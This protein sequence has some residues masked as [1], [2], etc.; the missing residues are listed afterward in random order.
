MLVM[1]PVWHDSGPIDRALKLIGVKRGL[2]GDRFSALGLGKFR[3]ND[4][5]TEA[6]APGR[7]DHG[8]E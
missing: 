3:S 4:D 7:R 6:A 1:E 8:R 2:L 5:L